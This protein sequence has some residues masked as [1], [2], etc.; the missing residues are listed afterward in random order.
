MWTTRRIALA[1][2]FQWLVPVIPI[3]PQFLPCCY[4]H[5]MKKDGEHLLR[6]KNNE[7]LNRTVY[8]RVFPYGAPPGGHYLENFTSKLVWKH[9]VYKIYAKI[10]K[11]TE[12][13]PRG[14]YTRKNPVPTI[15]F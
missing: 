6:Y 14:L 10:S 1:M 9:I 3:I 4:T 11:P 12:Y 15:I 2:L 8:N 5:F 7:V 13:S